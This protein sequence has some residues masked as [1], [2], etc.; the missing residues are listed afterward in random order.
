M[1]ES[2][3]LVCRIALLY[4]VRC[5]TEKGAKCERARKRELEKWQSCGLTAPWEGNTLFF[6]VII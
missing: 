6:S 2:H 5:R 4:P 1:P 3:E